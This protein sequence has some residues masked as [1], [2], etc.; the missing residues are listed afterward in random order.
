MTNIIERGKSIPCKASKTFTTFADNQHGVSIQVFEG[1]R[2]F[3]KDNNMLGRFELQGIA[4]APRGVPQIQVSFDLDANNILSVNAEEKASNG[5]SGVSKEIRIEQQ[6]G[7]LSAEEIER[8]VKDAEKHAAEDNARKERVE[9]RNSLENV[10][11]STKQQFGE[12][13]PS[14]NTF[15]DKLLSWLETSGESA[16]TEVLKQ[17]MKDLQDFVQ[18]EVQKSG[19]NPTGG[20]T[21]QNMQESDIDDID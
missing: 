8:I 7:R 13:I 12:K 6:K 3:T 17:K 21:A 16:T 11:Y 1:E 18:A 5:S 15:V 19:V 20:A 14:V 9:V 4:P 2:K 10:C